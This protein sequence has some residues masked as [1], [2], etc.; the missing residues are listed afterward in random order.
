MGEAMLK[1]MLKEMGE[2]IGILRR[3]RD[4]ANEAL[5]D[6]KDDL[7]EAKHTI[8]EQ[9]RTIKHLNDEIERLRRDGR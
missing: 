7:E 6:G 2:W 5:R 3:E 4:S 9:R 8:R 1:E